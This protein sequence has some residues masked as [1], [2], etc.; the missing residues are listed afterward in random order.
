MGQYYKFVNLTKKEVVNP[1]DLGGVA[2]L[3]EWCANPQAGVIPYLLW[4]SDGAGGGDHPNP[5][6]MKYLGRWAGD[7]IVL[8]GDYDSSD[9]YHKASKQ[10]L[11][12]SK[13]LLEEFNDFHN[14]GKPEVL[15]P[16]FIIGVK[17]I[18]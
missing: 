15:Q 18:D 5:E 6:K 3:I 8:I 11:D 12:I 4:Q 14:I 7:K 10:Y 13:D 1:W 17:D 16:D 9:L 2:K